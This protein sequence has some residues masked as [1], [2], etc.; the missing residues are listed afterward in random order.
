MNIACDLFMEHLNRMV[1]D[2]V[3]GLGSN[4]TP[5]AL[6]RIGKVVGT[7]DEVLKKFDED[8]NDAERSGGTRLP[9]LI[10]SCSTL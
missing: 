6:V 7:L 9:H 1:K 2:A 5:K 10:K 4:K 3:S 8:N